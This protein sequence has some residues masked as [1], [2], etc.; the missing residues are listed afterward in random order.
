MRPRR[1]AAEIGGPRKKKTRQPGFNEAAANG[2]GN[3]WHLE[4]QAS[5]APCFNEAAANGRGNRPPLRRPAAPAG[6]FNEAAANGRGNP[7][8]VPTALEC[9]RASM[10]PRRMAAEIARRGGRGRRRGHRFNEA[11]ANGRGNR[12]SSAVP[13][14]RS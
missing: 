2:R 3:R 10:R 7:A 8:P 12:T 9:A 6:R 13:L 5:V 11:A 1:M 4:A 14:V